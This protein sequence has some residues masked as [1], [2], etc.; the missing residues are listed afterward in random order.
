MKFAGKMSLYEIGCDVLWSNVNVL[1][2][3][4]DVVVVVQGAVL[5]ARFCVDSPYALA[6]G[7]TRNGFQTIDI[8]RL[9]PGIYCLFFLSTACVL[10]NI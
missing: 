6:V 5:C 10:Y 3:K 2:W 7:G 4:K 1:L 8:R 9:E